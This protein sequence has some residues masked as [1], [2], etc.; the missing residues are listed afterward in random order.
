LVIKTLDLDSDPF[1]DSLEMLDMDLNSMNPDPQHCSPPPPETEYRTNLWKPL[2]L[3]MSVQNLSE[4]QDLRAG[5]MI[6]SPEIQDF[7]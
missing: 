3:S 1:P 6:L 2:E 7:W 4:E 5:R